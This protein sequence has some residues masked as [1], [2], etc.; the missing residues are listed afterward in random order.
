MKQHR[1]HSTNTQTVWLNRDAMPL[2]VH[3]CLVQS[4]EAYYCAYRGIGTDDMPDSW[5]PDRH[6]GG[7]CSFFTA[8]DGQQHIIVSLNDAASHTPIE[9]AGLL[10][11]EAVHIWQAHCR[12]VGEDKPGDEQEAWTI[13]HIAQQLFRSYVESL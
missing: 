7:C 9:V 4:E 3:F 5:L 13:Q 1:W 2:Q 8:K 6:T 10:T 11:H 12:R